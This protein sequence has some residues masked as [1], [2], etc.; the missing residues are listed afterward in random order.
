MKKVIFIATTQCHILNFHIPDIKN[1]QTKGYEVHAVCKLNRK[2]RDKPSNNIIWHEINFDRSPVSVKNINALKRLIKL[3]QD[4]KFDI[5]HIH[6]PVTG[7]LG[8]IAA[9]ITKTDN[10][11]YTAHG[12]H[13]YK[14]APIINWILYYPIEKI[15][16]KY[17][18]YLITMNEEDFSIAYNKF[19]TRK[20]GSIFKVNGVGVELEKYYIDSK[21]DIEFKLSLGFDKDDFI[22][23]V[24]A[25][26]IERKN[27]KQIIN[28]MDIIYNKEGITD[29]KVA[30]VGEGELEQSLKKAVSDKNLES[31]V[32][33]LGY[34]KDIPKILNIT[35]VVASVSYQEGLPKNIMEALVARKPVIST[36]IRGSRELVKNN[37]NGIIVEIDDVIGTVNSIKKMY[38]DKDRLYDYGIKGFEIIEDYSI[39]NVVSQMEEI[40]ID[41]IR[42][43]N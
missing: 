33:F 19:K 38:Y 17:T 25:E 3:M 10:V 12:F 32:L 23:T 2:D 20:D 6:N 40:Y 39:E 31:N 36:N 16:A 11:I 27:H 7:V 43:Y 34:R 14:G 9:E 42:K 26:L 37:I 13:F 29:I 15:M 18:D 24:I 35:D 21:K 8:R 5:V 4:I 41:I 22:I 30:F 1:L 28:A